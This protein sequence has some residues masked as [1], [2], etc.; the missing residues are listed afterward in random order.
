[1][2]A[3]VKEQSCVNAKV[4]ALTPGFQALCKIQTACVHFDELQRIAL[5]KS[6]EINT[7]IQ[8]ISI[9]WT[10]FC[11]SRGCALRLIIL[12]FVGYQLINFHNTLHV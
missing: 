8:F 4:Y 3:V 6:S 7:K 9:L 2:L 1:M 5:D 10:Q 12:S 11:G